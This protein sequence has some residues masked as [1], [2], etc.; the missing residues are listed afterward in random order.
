MLTQLPSVPSLIPRSRATSA[1]GLP[2]SSTICTA[3]ALN[4]GLNLRRCSGMDRSS[5]HRVT[6]QD[7]WYTP[8]APPQ[9]QEARRWLTAAAEAGHSDAQ[10]RLGVL[11]KTQAPPQPAEARRW[12][13]A[14]AQEDA[15]AG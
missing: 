5:Q 13:T 3:S 8:A 7:R 11:L 14:A 6:V 10:E 15:D 12:L 2:V 1:M 4:C 9:P